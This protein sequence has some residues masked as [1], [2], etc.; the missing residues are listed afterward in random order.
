METKYW[1]ASP[2]NEIAGHIVNKVDAYKQYIDQSGM[3]DELRKSSKAFHGYRYIDTIQQSLK[4]I[5]VNH[6]GS[7]IRNV[8]T[9][10]TG[11]RPAW[12]PR[13][14]NT[15]LESQADTQ[16]AAGLLDYYMR[17]KHLEPKFIESVLRALYLREGWM[18]LDW[19]V[20]GGEVY[21]V[22]PES[23]EPIHEG[24]VEVNIHTILDVIRDFNRRDMNHDW[25]IIRK[26]KN[27]FDL[28]AKYPELAEKIFKVTPDN[29]FDQRYELDSY[30]NL[31]AANANE[32]DQIMTYTLYH[33]KT[34]A[35]PQG[36]MVQICGNDIV[37]FDGPLPYKRPYIFAITSGK[38]IDS[39]FGHSYLMDLLPVNEALN[40]TV[41]AILTNQAANAVQNFQGPKGATPKVTTVMDGMNYWEYDPKAGKIESMDLLKTAPEVFNFA[42]FLIQQQELLS[43]VSQIGRG[44]APAQLSGTAMALLQQQA[45][46][47]TAGVQT[48]YT[49]ALEFGGTALIELLQTFAVVPRMALIAGKSKRPMMREFTNKNLQGVTRVVVDSAN[50]LTKTGAGR[51]EIANQLLATQN[52][53]KTPEQYIGVLTTGN[54]EP[55]YQADNANRMLMLAENEQLMDGNPQQVLLTDDDGV[56]VMEHSV[57]LASPEARQNPKVIEV[58]L[59]HI[60]QHINN[61]KSKDPAV[62]AML[63]QA[64]F[65]QAPPPPAPGAPPPIGAPPPSEGPPPVMDNQNPITQE[66]SQASMPKPAEPPNPNAFNQGALQ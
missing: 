64:S 57:V 58:T 3:L 35:M 56:H 5:H 41:S 33:S 30:Q 11:S 61:G 43:N 14:I 48:S 15:D 51:M 20:T 66:A 36:R 13:A 24:D 59:D 9:M 42:N 63:K 53:I 23:G 4:A 52:M 27:K 12:E 6:Y 8:H 26:P 29:R 39:A 49:L 7:L 54:L 1:A 19:N 38:T 32:S 55:L 46:Q 17:E 65:F 47:S 34:E 37:L 44:N 16:L 18:S 45:I 31:L 22:N 28:A 25:Y 21:G 62:A 10:V 40:M 60:Q 2:N 50:P